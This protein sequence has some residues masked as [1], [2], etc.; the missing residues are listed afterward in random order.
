MNAKKAEVR[1][2]TV[3]EWPDK[4]YKG[5]YDKY[6]NGEI[7]KI[8]TSNPDGLR[9]SIQSTAHRLGKRLKSRLVEGVLYVQVSDRAEVPEGTEAE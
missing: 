1:E 9:S 8:E 4:P 2:S 3:S 5:K 6:M 7:W